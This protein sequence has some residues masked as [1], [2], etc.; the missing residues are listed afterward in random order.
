MYSVGHFLLPYFV[1]ISENV[2][3]LSWFHMHD[4]YHKI[5]GF[6]MVK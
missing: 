4:S 3:G 6:C 2:V 1:F 5:D